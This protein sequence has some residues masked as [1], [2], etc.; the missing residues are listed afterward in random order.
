MWA[1]SGN[2]RAKKGDKGV[3]AI[4]EDLQKTLSPIFNKIAAPIA[5]KGCEFGDAYG[6]I[7]SRK[8]VGVTDVYIDELVFPPLVQPYEQGGKTV[9]FVVSTGERFNER[10]TVTQMARLTAPA[11]SAVRSG[12]SDTSLSMNASPASDCIGP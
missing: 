4:V 2:Q 3:N 11:G 12:T 9:G 7:Y 6:R 8:G 5:L 1:C 10:L